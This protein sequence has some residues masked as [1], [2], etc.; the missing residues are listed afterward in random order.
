MDGGAGLRLLIETISLT[1]ARAAAA[2]DQVAG[3]GRQLDASVARVGAVTRRLWETGDAETAPPSV[4][5]SRSTSSSSSPA[6]SPPTAA[7]SALR[8]ER[9]RWRPFRQ[10]VPVLRWFRE[11]GRAH[12]P[13]RRAG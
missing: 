11:R 5:L 3:F 7:G 13:G 9:G 12:W 4:G 2:D 10:A 8:A 6:C 1:T